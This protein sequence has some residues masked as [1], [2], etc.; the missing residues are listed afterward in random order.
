MT[1]VDSS[2]P[3]TWKKWGGYSGYQYD[4]SEGEAFYRQWWLASERTILFIVFESNTESR[5]I[6]I[7]EINDIVNSITANT[8]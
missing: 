8:S 7:D 1:N 2:M 4:Y 6:K 5:D 3:L